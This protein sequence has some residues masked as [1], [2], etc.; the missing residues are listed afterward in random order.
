MKKTRKDVVKAGI[1]LIGKLL[2]LAVIV[3][4]LVILV[5]RGF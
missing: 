3:V 5:A 2:W 1:G 4:G